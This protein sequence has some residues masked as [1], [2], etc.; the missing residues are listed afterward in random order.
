MAR[1]GSGGYSLPVNTWNPA[2]NGV[3]AT[4][5]DY[6]ALINDLA[7][8]VQQSISADGQ[9]PVTGSLNMGGNRLT[10]LSAGNA[11]GHSL[12]FEQ[13]FSQGLQQDIAAAATVDIGAGLSVLVNV[14]GTGTITSFGT[15]YNGPRY[16]RF[17]GVYTLTNSATL[18]LPGGANITTAAGD[19]A[20][21]V[22]LG[23][24]ATGWRVAQYDRAD[25]GALGGGQ[26]AGMRNLIINGNLAINQRGYVSGAAVG[27]ANTYTLDRWRVVTSGQALTFT[28]SGNGNT[29]TAPA[30]GVE[31]VIEGA[32]IG[33]GTYVL[34][35]TG[36]ATAT[37]NGTP[38][39]KGGAFTLTA[40]T[41]ATVRLIGGTASL[42]QLEPGGTATPFEQR[43]IGLEL[44]L[45]Q[46]YLPAFKASNT[47]DFVPAIGLVNNA[48]TATFVIPHCVTPRVVPTGFIPST[49]LH[50]TVLT[51]AGGGATTS[52]V[53]ANGGLSA[54]RITATSSAMVAGQSAH[55]Y[56]TTAAAFYLFD[57]CEL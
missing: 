20:I 37:V 43:P 48:T 11:T 10:G 1:N 9:T 3:S 14:T 47:A 50:F 36:T 16:L 44:A 32:N 46:R 13:L 21:V 34:G 5:A 19:S 53:F 51:V 31:Q 52:L 30:G 40:N 6:Q 57:G 56:A 12:R 38:R 45:C 17:A 7:A 54:S 4:A 49:S 41:N 33:G 24:P 39:A 22:P 26:L 15:N 55:L 8:A 18:V 25:A 23:N 2:T 28:A 27:A 35:W 29:M 42:V